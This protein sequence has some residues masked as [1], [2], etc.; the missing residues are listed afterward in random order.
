MTALLK[1]SSSHVYATGRRKRS[2][3]RVYLQKGKGRVQVNDAPLS[4]FYAEHLDWHRAV[5]QP[6]EL[7]GVQGEYDVVAWVKGG[8]NT[9][10]A[11]ALRLG[12]ARALEATECAMLNI[13]VHAT[14]RSDEDRAQDRPWH[15]QLK[16]AGLLT[17][18]DRRVLR[19]LVGLVK[20]R[21][22]KQFSK[23]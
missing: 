2:V 4:S 16:Q 14:D 10:Q 8:G 3:A 11:E 21:K 22:R 20:H 1:V 6:L 12:I 7:L 19:K 5:V 15:D 17:R 9:G 13:P 18:D 23:R